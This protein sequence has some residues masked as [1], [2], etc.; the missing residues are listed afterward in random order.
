M[1]PI[2]RRF[3]DLSDLQSLEAATIDAVQSDPD[4]FLS[5][6]RAD[7]RSHGGR[8]ISSDLFKEMFQL[9]K[10]SNENRYRYNN[11]V[12]NSASVL[13]SLLFRRILSEFSES[14]VMSQGGVVVFLAG[15]PGSGKTSSVLHAEQWMGNWLAIYEVQL[16]NPTITMDKIKQVLDAGFKVRISV[17]H[18]LPE[19]ALRNTLYRCDQ[20][21]RGASIDIM[22]RIQGNLP[23]SLAE[24]HARFGNRVE[25]WI[26]DRRHHGPFGD[27]DT[28]AC[29]DRR[30]ATRTSRCAS[31]TRCSCSALTS[32]RP[33]IDQPWAHDNVRLES[34]AAGL[35]APR[36]AASSQA[37]LAPLLSRS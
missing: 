17:I 4:E 9:F 25:L 24:V 30:A 36:R 18:I 26:S 5:S 6:Y 23:D 31:T 37:A 10:E 1:E 13:A 27:G 2:R 35:R 28:C 20:Y 22:A 34:E 11:I 29:W 21:G 33:P 3:K 12:H 19:N 16:S 15:I 8:Y 14:N 7:E 32:A